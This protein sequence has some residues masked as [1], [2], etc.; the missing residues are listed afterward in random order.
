MNPDWTVVTT[1]ITAVL[2]LAGTVYGVRKSSKSDRD[3]LV[4]EWASVINEYGQNVTTELERIKE[5]ESKLREKL[6]EV[7]DEYA[8]AKIQHRQAMAEKDAIIR[9]RDKQILE[10][11]RE[12]D[13]TQQVLADSQ[14]MLIH[15]RH[16]LI[17]ARSLIK[18]QTE[19]IE[20]QRNGGQHASASG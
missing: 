11:R 15:T 12:L 8:E 2:V 9:D 3:K 10:L 18:I 17:A 19:F 6:I 16:E 4:Q 7:K 1:L 14:V 13:K 20:E 5:T